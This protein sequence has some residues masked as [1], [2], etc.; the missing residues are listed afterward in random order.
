MVGSLATFLCVGARKAQ[1]AR[2][3][4]A[5]KAQRTKGAE[6]QGV[7]DTKVSLN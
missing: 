5:P 6:T 1:G 4:R 7:K 3:L 2:V